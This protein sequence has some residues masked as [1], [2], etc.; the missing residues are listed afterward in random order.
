MGMGMSVSPQIWQQFV[1]LVFQ[2]DITKRKQNFDVIMDDTFIHSTK[3]EH[4]DD[5]MDLFKVLRTYGLKILPHKCQFFKKKI[6]Y[7]GLEF[8][9]KDR[10]VRYTPLKDRCEA[11][12]NLE[13]PK[14]LKQ[15]RAFCGM[16]NFLSSFLPNLRCFLIPIYDLQKNSKKF[17]W[18]E[19]AEK[20]F[21]EIKELLFSPPVLRAPN[22]EGLFN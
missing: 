17:K 19:E 2:N 10:K 3:E 16:V 18:T 1:D 9:V 20:A 13:S 4:M 14:T 11:I 7:M 6:V 12:R 22:P 5:L 21:K 8:Q 15:T